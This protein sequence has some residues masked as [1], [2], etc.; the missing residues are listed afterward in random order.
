[1]VNHICEPI[2]SNQFASCSSARVGQGGGG[3]PLTLLAAQG[4][5]NERSHHRVS[6]GRTRSAKPKVLD[7]TFVRASVGRIIC[8]DAAASAPP[9]STP[10]LKAPSSTASI[11]KPACARCP[12]ASPITRSAASPSCCPGTSILHRRFPPPPDPPLPVTQKKP[13]SSHSPYPP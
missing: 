3:A 6:Q 13:T 10:L 11:P 5:A 1:M 9:R 2:S 7:T 8:S 4:S 12:A